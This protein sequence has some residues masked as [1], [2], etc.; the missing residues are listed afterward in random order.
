MKTVNDFFA[1]TNIELLSVNEM[2]NVKGGDIPPADLS[3]P[4]GDVLRR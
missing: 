1:T 2:V 4:F 3:D